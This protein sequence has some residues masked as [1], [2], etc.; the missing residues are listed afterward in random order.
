M[1]NRAEVQPPCQHQEERQMRQIPP[2]LSIPSLGSTAC[3]ANPLGSKHLF[4]SDQLHEKVKA[5]WYM[6]EHWNALKRTTVTIGKCTIKG[7]HF[8]CCENISGGPSSLGPS[9]QP[10]RHRNKMV[11]FYFRFSAPFHPHLWIVRAWRSEDVVL[12]GKVGPPSS[13]DNQ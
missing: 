13:P 10:G 11:F 6:S 9:P 1:S 12:Y 2:I 8:Y 3:R 5:S 7:T 4:E